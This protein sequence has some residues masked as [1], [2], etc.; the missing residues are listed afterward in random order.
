VL[1]LSCAII[2]EIA[3]GIAMRAYVWLSSLILTLCFVGSAIS[4][5]NLPDIVAEVAAAPNQEITAYAV[6][7]NSICWLETATE[8]QKKINN[9]MNQPTA[10]AV[11]TIEMD[12]GKA[13]EKSVWEKRATGLTLSA[14]NIQV[15]NGVLQ[16]SYAEGM[17]MKTV[18]VREEGVN[19][20]VLGKQTLKGKPGEI[21][22]PV[23]NKFLGIQSPNLL[24]LMSID[25]DNK[26]RFEMRGKQGDN[27]LQFAHAIDIGET[28]LGLLRGLLDKPEI[29]ARTNSGQ[30]IFVF[31]LPSYLLVV[32]DK[33]WELSFLWQLKAKLQLELGTLQNQKEL[34]HLAAAIQYAN[35]LNHLVA[36][37]KV[38]E[39][40][41]DDIK[42]FVQE[43]GKALQTLITVPVTGEDF[44]YVVSLWEN[45]AYYLPGLSK[46]ALAENTNCS[47]L[48]TQQFQSV[49]YMQLNCSNFSLAPERVEKSKN[50]LRK[51]YS[52]SPQVITG[53]RQPAGVYIAN[54]PEVISSA[55]IH[56]LHTSGEQ[57]A[58]IISVET[59]QLEV[60]KQLL[61]KGIK[62][63][64]EWEAQTMGFA[65]V[66]K[67]QTSG[68]LTVPLDKFEEV[69]GGKEYTITVD[70]SP[71]FWEKRNKEQETLVIV[72]SDLT[73]Q[74]VVT[75]N[76]THY[77]IA[78]PQQSDAQGKPIYRFQ[79]KIEGTDKWLHEDLPFAMLDE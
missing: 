34:G 12:N 27:K 76:E 26:L 57:M 4:Q 45:K 9:V 24:K 28:G 43:S 8:K 11:K 61:A 33:Q 5:E 64:I 32:Y 31:A 15:D 73:K 21:A 49:L 14:K 1:Y 65:T 29:K 59:V 56:A 79:H 46:I 25:G 68:L 75:K 63:V 71:G 36:L 51:N 37:S 60:L 47:L 41:K 40:V 54:M 42:T 19:W 23:R 53:L 50:F 70:I 39:R 3:K 6:G 30:D 72:Y 16:F 48:H 18:C 38:D 7:K 67:M 13:T 44:V 17:A 66:E 58:G 78:F 22:F 69:S 52:L 55:K 35:F 74:L 10:I 77:T 62:V 20:R 2:F